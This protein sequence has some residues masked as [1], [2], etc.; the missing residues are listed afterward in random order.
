MRFAAVLLVLP[1]ACRSHAVTTVADASAPSTP[2]TLERPVAE[3]P[4]TPWCLTAMPPADLRAIDA[5][6]AVW[7]LAGAAL[8]RDGAPAGTLDDE[9]ACPAR[10][11]FAMEF[12]ADGA[13]FLVADGRFHVR[14]G[15]A[16]P[17]V[18]TPL[19][20]AIAGAPWSRRAG[21]GWSFI[22][23]GMRSIGPGLLSTRDATGASGW[24]A[25]T[26]LDRTITAAALDARNSMLTLANGGHAI[27][28]DQARTVA[29]ELLAAHGELFATLAR[30]AAG[31]T[32][33][34]DDGRRR[35]MLVAPT[36]TGDFARIE[37][38]RDAVEPTRYA[39]C[40][41]IAR[42]IATTER[43]VE[44]SADRGRTFRTVFRSDAAALARP[45]V[46][47]LRDGT[48]AVAM[49]GGIVSARCADAARGIVA[50]PDASSNP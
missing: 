50:A 31:I 12:E 2:R 21:G 5:D 35:V 28:V 13:A 9:I 34:R 29:G 45:S 27:V 11:T 17:F 15:A 26:A 30:T 39:A 19:C 47:R 38:T 3:A 23:S 43:S 25:T 46:G 48:L 14:A 7:S 49:R 6:G 8:T 33:A 18:V 41:D 44:F 22:P 36:L 37:G 10:G 40:A 32:L 16:L 20:T 24:F 1:G 4:A 42:C